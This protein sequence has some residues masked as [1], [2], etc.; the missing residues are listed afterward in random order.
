[1]PAHGTK[2]RWPALRWF[3]ARQENKIVLVR[4]CKFRWCITTS[5]RA[6]SI[7]KK[8]VNTV[9]TIAF[10]LIGDELTSVG[11]CQCHPE[12]DC[13][14]DEVKKLFDNKL[15]VDS[16]EIRLLD[17][18]IFLDPGYVDEHAWKILDLDP[19]SSGF[20]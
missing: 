6:A 13:I 14:C 17:R 2:R 15:S 1:M 18:P 4:W 11:E 7:S 19:K 10:E 8:I 16:E 5:I 20:D 3:F 9:G 12:A